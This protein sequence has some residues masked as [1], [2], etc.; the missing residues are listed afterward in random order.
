M[1]LAH[2]CEA[3]RRRASLKRIPIGGTDLDEATQEIGARM[4]DEKAGTL[5]TSIL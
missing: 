3:V 2:L 4:S 1:F 5:D